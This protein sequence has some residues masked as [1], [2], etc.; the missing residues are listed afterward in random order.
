MGESGTGS[1]HLSSPPDPAVGWSALHHG[2]DPAEVPLLGRWLR[3]MWRLSRPL[4]RLRVPPLAITFLGAVLAVDAMLLAAR[5]PWVAL[6]LVLL[7][8]LCDGLDGAVAM[9]ARRA[10][11]FGSAAD[12]AADR[13]ADVSFA[14]V[15]WQSGAPLWLALVAGSMSLLH[16][17]VR[18]VRGGVL[19]SRL[20]VAERPTRVVCASVACASSGVSAAAWPPTVCAA[21]W[22]GL[23]LLGLL[24]LALAR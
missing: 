17:L 19:V 23:A 11:T 10:S 5:H 13:V 16:E 22:V 24:Q 15:L 1:A 9:L 2:I 21:V 14:L 18:T 12:K 8:A 20:T 4:V 7:S 3:V 6:G